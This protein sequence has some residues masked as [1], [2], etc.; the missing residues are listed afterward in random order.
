MNVAAEPV[1]LGDSDRASLPVAAGFSKGGDEL[2]PAIERV[3]VFPCL[4]L[5]V[6]RDDL[7][8][9]GLGE[10]GVSRNQSVLHPLRSVSPKE[11]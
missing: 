3:G 4:D 7:E 10:A 5:D 9:L 1:E 2:W 6:L 11:K 8:P